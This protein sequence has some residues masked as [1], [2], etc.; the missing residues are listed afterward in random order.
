MPAPLVAIADTKPRSIR[1]TSTGDRPVFSTC[2][3]SPQMIALPSRFAATIAAT[4]SLKS[5]AA[6]S[7]GSDFSNP[8]TPEPSLYGV[9]N[10][11]RRHLALPRAQRIGLDAGQIEFFVGQF[12]RPAVSDQGLT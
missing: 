9:A 8:S 6:S 11:A 2:A 4:T 1:S 7:P 5:C 10:C 12:H 3:P